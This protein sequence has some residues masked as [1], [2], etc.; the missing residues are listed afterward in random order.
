MS[1]PPLT[2]TQAADFLKTTRSGLYAMVQRRQV[3]Y[4]RVGKRKILFFKEDLI[5]FLEKRVV[6]AIKTVSPNGDIKY[7]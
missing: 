1:K 4:I 7:W 2:A 6:P 3:P 5:E